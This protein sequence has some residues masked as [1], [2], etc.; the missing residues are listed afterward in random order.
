MI[1]LSLAL[2]LS[3]LRLEY[4]SLGGYIARTRTRIVMLPLDCVI[5]IENAD[6]DADTCA[7]AI[8]RIKTIISIHHD[9]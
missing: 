5:A 8:E 3:Y 7:L 2:V 9:P 1:S 4:L 6:I